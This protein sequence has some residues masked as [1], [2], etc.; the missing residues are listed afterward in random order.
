MF[1]LE[2]HTSTGGAR[3]VTLP[4]HPS[5]P[6]VFRGAYTLFVLWSELVSDWTMFQLYPGKNKSLFSE[7][8]ISA[9]KLRAKTNWLEVPVE[10]HFHLSVS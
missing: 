6:L 10:K 7:I 4:V 3:T 8:I 2:I 5:L 1:I 9:F